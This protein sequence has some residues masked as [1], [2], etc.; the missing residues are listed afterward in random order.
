MAV[1]KS[2][3]GL[4]Q[5]GDPYEKNGKMYILIKTKAGKEKEVRW[6]T[7]KEYQKLYGEAAPNSDFDANAAF[8]FDSHF[9]ALVTNKSD[10]EMKDINLIMRIFMYSNYFGWF[11]K[12]KNIDKIPSSITWKKLQWDAVST[13]ISPENVTEVYRISEKA[14]KN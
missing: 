11:V 9:I 7:A 14:R 12:Y 5:C 6:Y 10:E 1:A 4:P 3:V 2:Y 8:G 13:K